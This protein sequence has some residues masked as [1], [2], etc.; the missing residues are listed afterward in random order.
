MGIGLIICCFCHYFIIRLGVGE[1]C[2][3]TLSEVSHASH[4]LIVGGCALACGP[5]TS[6]TSMALVCNCSVRAG[7]PNRANGG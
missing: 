3:S 1:K 7:V 5:E 6:G 2:P 4:Y